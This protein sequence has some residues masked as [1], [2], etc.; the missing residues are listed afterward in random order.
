MIRIV[1]DQS[2]PEP[3]I[4]ITEVT[5]PVEIAKSQALFARARLNSD[6]LQ[7]HWKDLLPQARGKFVAVAGQETHIADT[8]QD[9]WTW[10]AAAHPEDDGAMVQYV[11]DSDGPRIYAHRG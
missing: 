10:A 5:D 8:P 2:I 4:V 6:W 11:P 7:S 9:A 3:E 1:S